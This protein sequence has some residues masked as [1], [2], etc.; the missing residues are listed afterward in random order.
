MIK[1]I[2]D[3]LNEFIKTEVEILNNQDIKH[4]TT[5]GTM[6]EGLTEEVLKR[7]IFGGLNLRVVKNSFIIGCD[8]EFDILLVDKEGE[9]IPHTDRYKFKPEDIIAII[10][11]KKN[12]YS[13]DIQEGY[14]NL[15]F[16]ID[17][18]EPRDAE[19]YI[20]NLFRDS[21]RSICKKNTTAKN[22]GDLTIEERQIFHTLRIEAFLP[23]RIILGYNGFSS[24]YNFREKFVEYLRKNLT[25]DLNDKKQGFGPHNFPSLI[26]CG[27]YS[28]IKNNGMPFIATLSDDKWWPFYTTSSFNSTN[29]FLETIWTRLSY[30]YDLPMDIFGE[31]LVMEPHTKFLDC[32]FKE[33]DG[34]FGWEFDYFA[35][36]KDTLLKNVETAD[37]QPIEIDIAQHT[38]IWELCNKEEINL[39]NN[40]EM[41]GFAKSN[42]YKSLE[43]FI[44]KLLATGL[45]SVESKKLK[46][47]T[48]ECQCAIL[49]DGRIVAGENKSGRFQRWISKE[50]DKK[51]NASS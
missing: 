9:Q 10:Q 5:I 21:F 19:Q 14:D 31:D 36:K 22:S 27:K 47:L 30:K 28:M 43:E 37:W 6:F 4:P 16:I 3:L 45:V 49:P 51:K 1:S 8:T 38:I 20:A 15:K 48:D 12:L 18:F 33:I 40:N 46:L 11:V 50:I 42:S 41:E 2:S 7:S 13:K 34:H 26:I 32:R 23:V 17:S 35:A 25:T 44:D 29:F 24:E 39:E